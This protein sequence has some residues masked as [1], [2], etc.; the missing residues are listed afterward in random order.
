MAG[1][2]TILALVSL[3]GRNQEA[4]GL[5]DEQ[6]TWF[7]PGVRGWRRRLR[8]SPPLDDLYLRRS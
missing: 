6:E 7:N 1:I 2:H 5:A 8:S 3:E 4:V